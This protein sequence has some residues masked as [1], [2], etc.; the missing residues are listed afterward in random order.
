MMAR[1]LG[2]DLGWEGREEGLRLIE[3][4]HE[5]PCVWG[6]KKGHQMF[7]GPS[8]FGLYQQRHQRARHHP[9]LALGGRQN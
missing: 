6:N 9:A 3:W 5:H 4:A 7:V 8:A 1:Y 2:R